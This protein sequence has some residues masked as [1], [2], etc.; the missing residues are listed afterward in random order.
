MPSSSVTAGS[1]KT[2][3]VT[4]PHRDLKIERLGAAIAKIQTLAARSPLDDDPEFTQWHKGTLQVLQELFTESHML[5]YMGRF[6]KI[7]F[8]SRIR[9]RGHSKASFQADYRE[10]WANG[11][12]EAELVLKEALEDAALG[13][14]VTARAAAGAMQPQSSAI[15]VNVNN[16]ISN[17]FSPTLHVTLAELVEALDGRGLT[18]SERD[19]A[20]AELEAIDLETAG[21]QRWPV[22]ARSLETLKSFGKGVYKDFAVP[23]IVE[24]LKQQSG[25]KPPSQ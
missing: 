10:V 20:R 7:H 22:I 5:G 9:L 8:R 16:Y 25:L 1:S 23:L 13:P 12:R 21:Q 6:V 18:P 24:F 4:S 15:V 17:A 11:L 19:A 14:K 2:G 3:A